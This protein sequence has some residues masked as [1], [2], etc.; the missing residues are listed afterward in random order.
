MKNSKLICAIVVGF[1]VLFSGCSESGN[2]S[3]SSAEETKQR[4]NAPIANA[5]TDQFLDKSSLETLNGSASADIDGD[6]ITY[7]WSIISTPKDSEIIL[8]DTKAMNP[9]FRPDKIG[10]YIF[11][12]VVSDGENKSSDRVT[13]NVTS[14]NTLVTINGVAIDGY[15]DGATVTYNGI[16]VKTNSEGEWS[17]S[18]DKTNSIND[19]VVSITGGTDTATGE[20]YE[21]ILKA[22]VNEYTKEI[23]VT[24]LTTIISSLVESGS[25]A[26]EATQKVSLQLNIPV[27][28]LQAD[29][30]KILQTGTV[31]EKEDAAK[32]I[33]KALVIQKTVESLAKSVAH[34][35]SDTMNKVM[36]IMIDTVAQSMDGGQSFDEVMSDTISIA[37]SAAVDIQK[38][39]SI[40]IANVSE[41]LAAGAV[42]AKSVVEL[43]EAIDTQE[44][45]NATDVDAMVM[46]KS[47]AVEVATTVIE[48]RAQEIS[49]ATTLATIESKLEDAVTTTQAIVMLGGVEGLAET[50][51]Q[52]SGGD[53]VDASDFQD[54]CMTDKV[55]EEQSIIYVILKTLDLSDER[56][57]QVGEDS[58]T[59]TD[60]DLA[61][62][63]NKV[64]EEAIE[65]GE[66]Q[67]DSVDSVDEIV[68][69]IG[70][71][72][73]IGIEIPEPETTE[74]ETTKPETTEPET[75][76]PETTESE[77]TEPETTE[78]ED[79]RL[80][81][82]STRKR[83]NL[84]SKID[85]AGR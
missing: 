52:S 9:T 21:G 49:Q 46:S 11:E 85:P 1:L 27:N 66:I 76:D 50:M 75:T 44:L 15:L 64:V 48:D 71:E 47:K 54:T 56:I 39:E 14:I 22:P 60:S 74:P 17:I 42:I 78:P 7:L 3:Q 51:E 38:D 8:S 84:P 13:V 24:P 61:E 69:E 19:K 29:P 36:Q 63:I 30:I 53:E 73:N 18:Y 32:A 55:M 35:D 45:V 59:Q 4:N 67:E 20:E 83:V 6:N 16:S 65:S 72:I 10:T 82:V 12:L 40:E 37:A 79:T 25:S 31:S 28:I 81:I 58:A 34:T 2:I 41:K 62:V 33:K 26:E 77:T 70:T 57:M 23:I 68:K 80:N 43:V 5:G